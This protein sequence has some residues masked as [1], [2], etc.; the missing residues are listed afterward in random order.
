MLVIFIRVHQAEAWPLMAMEELTS[1][2]S[3]TCQ[4]GT[5]RVVRINVKSVCN[6]VQ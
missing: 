5:D 6:L 1:R 2:K 3:V 4:P